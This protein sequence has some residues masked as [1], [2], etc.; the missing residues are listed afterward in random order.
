M[1]VCEDDRNCKSCIFQ[2]GFPTAE[3]PPLTTTK[4]IVQDQGILIFCWRFQQSFC[5]HFEV[6]QIRSLFV[7]QFMLFHKAVISTKHQIFPSPSQLLLWLDLIQM[8]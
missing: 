8:K 5:K 3:M 6:I 2:T 1:Q 7:Q 4:F